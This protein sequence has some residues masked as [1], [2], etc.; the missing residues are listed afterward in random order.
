MRGAPHRE[1]RW[2]IQARGCS[3][4]ARR[5]TA[6]R[7]APSP[8]RRQRMG[9]RRVGVHPGCAP[10]A[11]H[12]RGHGRSVPRSAERE[13][14]DASS[15]TSIVRVFGRSFGAAVLAVLFARVRRPWLGKRCGV[16]R[17]IQRRDLL[18]D[19]L[20][21]AGPRPGPASVGEGR[22]RETLDPRRPIRTRRAHRGLSTSSRGPIATVRPSES[23][24]R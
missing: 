13:V 4:R 1:P 18:G 7:R 19:R 24:L 10:G 11:G 16:R 15:T 22:R 3:A 23:P 9:G 6:T 20:R 17:C 12:H 14:P 8:A 5:P 2:I 21:L